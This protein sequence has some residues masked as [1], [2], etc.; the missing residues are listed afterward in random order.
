MQHALAA[1][2]YI[3]R[4]LEQMQSHLRSHTACDGH[5]RMHCTCQNK[6]CVRVP[7][8]FFACRASEPADILLA[9][10]HHWRMCCCSCQLRGCCSPPQMVVTTTLRGLTTSPLTSSASLGG[11]SRRVLLMSPLAT[12][13]LLKSA[14]SRELSVIPLAP[15]LL[16][17]AASRHMTSRIGSL[18]KLPMLK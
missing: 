6:H 7:Y 18:Q 5:S 1:R 3:V 13:A 15:V 17:G 12:T 11:T 8:I 16:G 2:L 10:L 4:V 9:L 14:C